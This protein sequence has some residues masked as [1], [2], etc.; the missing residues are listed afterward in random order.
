MVENRGTRSRIAAPS[1]AILLAA[2]TCY[3]RFGIEATTMDHVAQ[4]AGLSRPTVY[5]YYPTRQTLISSVVEYRAND[6]FERARRFMATRHRIDDRLVDG[7]IYLV[8]HGS[9]DPMVM[10]LFSLTTPQTKD[11]AVDAR[12]LATGL[13]TAFWVPLLSE[14]QKAS[15]IRPDL[16]IPEFASWLVAISLM[17]VARV[18]RLGAADP[19]HKQLL[20]RFVVP[21]LHSSLRQ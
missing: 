13:A 3:A 6:L 18:E 17:M 15:R 21:L 2:E 5:R 7:M 1:T 14:A 20:R 11:A 16:D 4:E 19:S 10:H 9:R 8:D 12:R